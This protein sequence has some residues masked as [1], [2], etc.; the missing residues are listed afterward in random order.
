MQHYIKI[1]LLSGSIFTNGLLEDY[2]NEDIF[3]KN[4]ISFIK[5]NIGLSIVGLIFIVLLC[6]D[7]SITVWYIVLKKMGIKYDIS[8]GYWETKP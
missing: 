2:F 8:G 7:I 6:I 3:F 1:L 5:N 4:K